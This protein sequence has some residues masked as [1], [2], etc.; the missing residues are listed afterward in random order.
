ML[1]RCKLLKEQRFHFRLK[2]G[3]VFTAA[4]ISGDPKDAFSGRKMGFRKNPLVCH[5]CGAYVFFGIFEKSNDFWLT[6]A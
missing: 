1:K 3:R 5:Y 6:L 2:E 4:Q